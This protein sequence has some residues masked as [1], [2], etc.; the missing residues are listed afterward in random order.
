MSKKFVP[1]KM[2]M[3]QKLS[4]EIWLFDFIFGIGDI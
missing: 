3:S 4:F 1:K 2:K